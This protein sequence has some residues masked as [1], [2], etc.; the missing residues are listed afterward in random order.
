MLNNPCP[1]NISVTSRNMLINGILRM[2]GNG[3]TW[4]Q[5]GDYYGITKGMAYRIANDDYIPANLEI[6]QRL[7]LT[8]CCW[9]DLP[10]PVVRWAIEHREEFTY[11]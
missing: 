10:T 4:Q 9:A 5:I 8:P 6:R 1:D 3:Q 7:G 2:R 11:A